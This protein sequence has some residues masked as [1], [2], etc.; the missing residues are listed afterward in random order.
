MGGGL[1]LSG[2][3][4]RTTL[5]TRSRLASTLTPTSYQHPTQRIWCGGM[6]TS[7]KWFLLK[8]RITTIFS[9]IPIH[10]SLLRICVT[11]SEMMPNARPN[12]RT[13]AY[14]EHA[15]ELNIDLP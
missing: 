1:S 5:S 2:S 6:Q 10:H 15:T 11:S 9:C 8:R 14:G 3:Q 7:S 13:L 12:D 4:M